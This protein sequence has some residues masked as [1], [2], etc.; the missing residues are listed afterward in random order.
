MNLLQEKLVLRVTIVEFLRLDTWIGQ[1]EGN[2]TI[3][4]DVKLVTH[5][6]CIKFN[7]LCYVKMTLTVIVD[8]FVAKE[9]FKAKAIL[10]F[11]GPAR[12]YQLLEQ[13]D[14]IVHSLLGLFDTA[15]DLRHINKRVIIAGNSF[16][17]SY[18][19]HLV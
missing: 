1:L 8:D 3:E 14:L 4:H 11:F 18:K 9:V 6:T 13:W 5:F 12:L 16:V 10:K 19:F 2:L 15:A 7:I 17:L